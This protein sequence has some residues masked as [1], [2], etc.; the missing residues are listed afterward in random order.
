MVNRTA[1][2]SGLVRRELEKFVLSLPDAEILVLCRNGSIWLEVES[3]LKGEVTQGDFY[4]LGLAHDS[5][6]I[7]LGLTNNLA[8]IVN[9]DG[10]ADAFYEDHIDGD[11]KEFYASS[12]LPKYNLELG[13]QLLA[14]SIRL[15]FESDFDSFVHR[16]TE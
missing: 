4:A 12:S 9:L 3:A 15:S 1:L 11:D 14:D 13:K 6:T 7:Q 10:L 2:D 8:L 16:V 5:N